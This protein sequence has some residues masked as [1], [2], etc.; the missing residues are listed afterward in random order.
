M[1]RLDS[2]APAQNRDPL[3][4]PADAIP[5]PDLWDVGEVLVS[6]VTILHLEDNPHDAELIRA[7]LERAGFDPA[8]DRVATREAFVAALA[9]RRYDLI[10]AE[11]E[12][13]DFNGPAALAV[14][15]SAAPDTPFLFVSRTLGEELAIESLKQGATDYV[16]KNR[17]ERLAPAVNR[18]LA[19]A[20]ERADRRRAEADRDRAL[21]EARAAR[22]EAEAAN[23]MKDQFLSTL[24]HELRTPLNAILG[25][26][27]LL[28]TGKLPPDTVREGLAVI[29]RNAKAQAQLISDLLDVS[30]IISGKLKIDPAP[31]DVTDAVR[32]AIASVQPTADT[33]GVAIATAIE[34]GMATVNGDTARLQQVVWNLLTNAIKFTPAGGRIDLAVRPVGTNLEV[35]V[36][37]T[38]DG[39]EPAFLPHVFDRFRQADPS[40]TRQHGGLGLGLSIVRQLVEAHGGTVQADSPGR[41]HGAT[42][43]VTIPR[44]AGTRPG[45]DDRA[46]G[47]PPPADLAGVRVL[48]VDDERDSREM[49]GLALTA[50]GAEVV[51]AGSVD[52]AIG[53]LD[54]RLPDAVVSDIGMPRRDG[55]DLVREVLGRGPVPAVAL[56]AFVGPDDRRRALDAGYKAHLGKPIDPAALVAAVHGL[57]TRSGRGDG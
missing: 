2:F 45:P 23:R 13:P 26:A 38:G 40:I 20:R 7:R 31:V 47:L 18:A 33:K 22:D 14:A 50:A 35:V 52:E 9:A 24:S 15:R 3:A 46:G 34:P 28:G 55:Y 29:E 41:G 25:W 57:L 6:W 1:V 8:V 37:D 44:L 43:T 16:V 11:D 42:F 32:A 54:A 36:R 17:P 21:A 51:L 49:A 10:L 56:T 30:R 5:E 4:A 48:V 19:G 27:K 12:L 53:H 39:I